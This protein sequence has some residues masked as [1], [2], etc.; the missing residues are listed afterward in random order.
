MRIATTAY[1]SIPDDIVLLVCYLATVADGPPVCPPPYLPLYA[2]FTGITASPSTRPRRP[3][4]CMT[5]VSFTG[6]TASPSTRP[7]RPLSC[8]TPVSFT[9]TIVLDTVNMSAAAQRGT[10]KDRL[11]ISFLEPLSSGELPPPAS[12]SD[13]RRRQLPRL[14]ETGVACGSGSR[15]ETRRT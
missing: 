1:H 8:M 13:T 3:Q 15:L 11:M 6:T 10:P 2:P 14:A 7:R 5:T 9:G 4:S 12:H